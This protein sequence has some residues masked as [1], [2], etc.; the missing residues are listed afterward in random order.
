MRPFSMIFGK[1][2]KGSGHREDA[3]L[4]G[5]YWLYFKREIELISRNHSLMNLILIPRKII[6]E[7]I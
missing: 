4:D 1:S 6:E 2:W 5:R 3:V 7:I